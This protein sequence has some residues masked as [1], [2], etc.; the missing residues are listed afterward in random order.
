MDPPTCCCFCADLDIAF[1]QLSAKNYQELLA[2]HRDSSSPSLGN[3]H[4]PAIDDCVSTIIM[5]ERD[6]VLAHSLRRA[7]QLAGPSR[8]VVGVVGVQ[9]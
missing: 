7:A 9:I 6:A 2:K 3:D 4:E 1:G 8:Q 5:E